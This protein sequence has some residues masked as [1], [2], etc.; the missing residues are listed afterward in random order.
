ML[1]ASVGVNRPLVNPPITMMKMITIHRTSIRE[2][3]L[4]LHVNLSLLGP[5]EGSILHIP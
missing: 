1:P 4:S 3:I 2:A 5:R